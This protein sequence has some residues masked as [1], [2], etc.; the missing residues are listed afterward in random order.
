MRRIRVG[1]T[2]TGEV[3]EKTL[4]DLFANYNLFANCKVVSNEFR[5]NYQVDVVCVIFTSSLHTR[6][7]LLL[8]SLLLCVS[9][10]LVTL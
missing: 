4:Q 5:S 9:I 3:I 1:H 7:V 10:G 2:V 8:L 6:G